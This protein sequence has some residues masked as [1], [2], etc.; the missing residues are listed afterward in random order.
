MVFETIDTMTHKVVIH[1][2]G[3]LPMDR[4]VEEIVALVVGYLRSPPRRP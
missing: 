4:Y 1:G 2:D 3:S